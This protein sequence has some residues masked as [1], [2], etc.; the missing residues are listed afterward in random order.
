MELQRE[1]NEKDL[2]DAM[3]QVGA[4]FG[5]SKS[6]RHPSVKSF[7]FGTKNRTEIINLEEVEKMLAKA[8]AYMETLGR[9]GKQVLFVGN[10]PEA[11]SAVI[12]AAT[13]MGGTYSRERW[14]GGTFTNLPEIKKRLAR[15]EDLEGRKNRGELSIYPKK[16]IAVMEQELSNLKRFFIGLLPMKQLPTALVIVDPRKEATALREAKKTGVT[17][18]ALA[19]SD[20][21]ISEVD[22][23]IVANDASVASITFFVEKLAAAYLRGKKQAAAEAQA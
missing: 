15:F 16:E 10:K 8:E 9:E 5:F 1:S 4:H 18:V 11:M 13:D 23:P 21:D 7:I 14:I 6:R 19:G 17:V 3:F 22:Y 12:K 2:I 20:C